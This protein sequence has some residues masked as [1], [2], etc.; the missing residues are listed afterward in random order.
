[1]PDS[2]STAREDGARHEPTISPELAA[3]INAVL[4]A[5]QPANGSM[6]TKVPISP[7]LASLLKDLPIKSMPC[8]FCSFGSEV[9]DKGYDISGPEREEVI[10][11]FER[12]IE[13]AMARADFEE[14]W[15]KLEY[16]DQNVRN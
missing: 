6:G 16:Q 4:A 8:N 13:G 1:M 11:D 14:K 7:R 9:G 15:A 3:E 2:D 10:A 12:V 5:Q